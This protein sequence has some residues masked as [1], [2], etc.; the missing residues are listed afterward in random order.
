MS[1]QLTY[2]VLRKA[3]ESAAAFRCR[4]KLQP[5][6]GEGDK[7][8]P[9]TY[10]GAVYA[11]EQRRVKGGDGNWSSGNVRPA[12]QRSEPGESD[13]RCPSRGDRREDDPTA[14]CRGRF[15]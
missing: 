3:T 6:G 15:F 10:A 4:R 8:F 7:V 13:G 11:V 2:E 14:A 12:G 9:P 5:A 1:E